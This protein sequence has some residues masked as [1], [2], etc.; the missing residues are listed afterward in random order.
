MGE[1]PGSSKDKSESSSGKGLD[2]IEA[3]AA[4][5]FFL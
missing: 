2:D 1:L 5:D 4:T 3:N